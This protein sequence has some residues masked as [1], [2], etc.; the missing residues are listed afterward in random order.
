MTREEILTEVKRLAESLGR[1]PGRDIFEKETGVRSGDWY[2]KY[3]LRWG[4]LLKDA[5]LQRNDFMQK[6]DDDIIIRHY[7]NFVRELGRIP[8]AGEIRNRR[9]EISSFPSHGVFNRL[10]GRQIFLRKCLDVASKVPEFTDLI[11]VLNS[12]LKIDVQDEA[13]DPSEDDLGAAG[14]VY[15]MRSGKYYKIGRTNSLLRREGELKVAIPIPPETIHSIQTDDPSGVEAYW[16]NRFDSKRGEGEWFLFS[17]ADI[18]AF[19]K[20]KKIF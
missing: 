10:G 2:P 15:L 6:M 16:H 12:G 11:P 9:S 18:V 5:E 3:W 17:K 13:L 19:R 14:C 4:D 8:V 7:L 1:A 20:W